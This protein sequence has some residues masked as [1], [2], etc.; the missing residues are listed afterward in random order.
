MASTKELWVNHYEIMGV[1]P[2]VSAR[3]L[4]KAYRDLSRKLHPDKNPDPNAA[5]LFQ[6]MKESYEVLKDASRRALFDSKLKAKA[7]RFARDMAKSEKTRK[8]KAALE[9]AEKAAE[10]RARL[11]AL[12]KMQRRTK[13]SAASSKLAS[14]RAETQRMK[15]QLAADAG[16][17]ARALARKRAVDAGILSPSEAATASPTA[18]GGGRRRS[19]AALAAAVKVLIATRNGAGTTWCRGSGA[20][21]MSRGLLYRR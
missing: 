10:E 6:A 15:Q 8:M 5:T 9:A 13:G 17:S 12:A 20:R 14:L 19:S 18:N 2:S 7:I 3:D 11:A 4:V 1:E 16:K 21:Q